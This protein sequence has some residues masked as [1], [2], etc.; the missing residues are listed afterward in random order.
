MKSSR[1]RLKRRHER[2]TTAGHP[3]DQEQQEF[4]YVGVR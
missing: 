2:M 3:H 4:P 1:D